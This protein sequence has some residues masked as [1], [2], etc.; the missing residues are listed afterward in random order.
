MQASA[1]QPGPTVSETAENVAQTV[2]STNTTNT[3]GDFFSGLLESASDFAGSAAN[4]TGAFFADIKANVVN[5]ADQGVDFLSYDSLKTSGESLVNGA[6]KLAADTYES[7]STSSPVETAQAWI[8][9]GAESIGNAANQSAKLTYSNWLPVA[10]V[11]LSAF[12]ALKST[13]ASLQNFNAGNLKRAVVQ[14]FVG[15]AAAALASSVVY[16][17]GALQAAG[18]QAQNYFNSFGSKEEL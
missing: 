15:A 14:I 5:F 10:V 18:A 8:G 9:S 7:L 3:D 1:Q 13:Q 2:N 4:T 16:Q 12:T 11:A 6:G 17:T